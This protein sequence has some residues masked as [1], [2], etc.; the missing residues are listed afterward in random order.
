MRKIFLSC[1]KYFGLG[2][3]RAKSTFNDLKAKNLDIQFLRDTHRLPLQLQ[4]NYENVD[5]VLHRSTLQSSNQNPTVMKTRTLIFQSDEL[6]LNQKYIF[7]IKSY[8]ISKESGKII[9]FGKESL[10]FNSYV[11]SIS[12]FAWIY[13]LFFMED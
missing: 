13:I 11:S 4:H 3:T 2:K 9:D 1:K 5:F 6:L 8:M 7:F 12:V 10:P